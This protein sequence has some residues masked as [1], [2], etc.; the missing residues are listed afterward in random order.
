MIPL[1]LQLHN[2]MSYGSNSQPL[3]FKGI[4]LACLSGVNGVGKSSLLEAIT[5]AL[6]GKARA[7]SD[8]D[9]IKLG[10]QDMWVDFVFDLEG[11]KY[12]VVRKRSKQG[13]GQSSLEFMIA[14]GLEKKGRQE[15]LS[16]WTP[17]TGTTKAET[18]EAIVKTLR[19]EYDTF[20]NSAF[21]RQGHADE[22]TVKRP[23]ERKAILGDILGLSY[24]DHLESQAKEL[25]RHKEIEKESL[26]K[27]LEDM[28]L[29]LGDKKTVQ[30]EVEKIV[31]SLEGTSEEIQ[32]KEKEVIDLQKK[33]S[34]FETDL[35]KIEELKL[36]I[37]DFTKDI[38]DLNLDIQKHNQI[39]SVVQKLISQKE[40]IETKFEDYKKNLKLN[41]DYNQKLSKQ[42]E[43]NKQRSEIERNIDQK[44]H[45]LE[46]EKGQTK[47]KLEEIKN[48]L[49]KKEEIEEEKN[50]IEKELSLLKQKE[51]ELIEFQKDYH[52][53][54][55]RLAEIKVEL[56]QLKT[57]GEEIKN[58]ITILSKAKADCP[59]CKQSLTEEHRKEVIGELENQ[60]IQ[61]REEYKELR[62]KKI[63]FKEKTESLEENIKEIEIEL[64]GKSE[65]E[66]KLTELS[67][68]LREMENLTQE[69]KEQIEKYKKLSERLEGKDYDPE[70][71]KKLQGL[72]KEI[73]SISYD[74]KEHN[75]VKEKVKQLEKYGQLKSKL[76]Q[77]KEK[78]TDSKEAR[79][80]IEEI[81]KRKKVSIE[82][83]T[84]EK[85]DLA[86]SIK[87]LEIINNK[88]EEKNKTLIDLR[89]KVSGVQEEYGAVKE[90]YDRL[91]KIKEEEKEKQKKLKGAEEEKSVYDELALA[92]SKKG[93]QAMIIESAIPEIEEEANKLLSRMTDGKM[94][95]KFETQREKKTDGELQE[96]LD[97][98]ISDEQGMRAY[99]L[100][101]G[102]EAYRI[103]FAIRVALSK[104]LAHR[105]GAKLQFLVID[106]GFGTQDIQ[107]REH[108]VEAINSI[109]S[110]FKKILVITHIP[111]LREVFPT[112]IEVTKDEEGS[113][114]NVVG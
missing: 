38:Q 56:K 10:N 74:K 60:L 3:D 18:Q 17:M 67:K 80:R 94:Q 102:G 44:K 77:A 47:A 59:L 57:N 53:I 81:I 63:T 97:I 72:E 87:K 92:F 11:T 15:N 70:D 20:I 52:K 33:K 99:E 64:T 36:R 54:K 9:L 82:K 113:H 86:Q 66:K 85:E 43:L 83:D 73:F 95:V 24:Y 48:K 41:E 32:A 12:R 42:L 105:A 45:K 79:A 29:Q 22:F 84:K 68:D 8:D 76:D 46:M 78:I 91:I 51:K 6:W 75:Q 5:W 111:E 100:F 23:A 26:E 65:V 112:R 2:F 98:K 104:L 109:S 114:L 19:M 39:I 31:K 89:V 14:S 28:I 58:K 106:E 37:S 21:L 30:K 93:V 90:K 108:L 96:T 101:S 62:S 71:F 107:G 88:L 13:K 40:D 50:K 110:E 25:S 69:E 35:K 49:A 55:E 27:Q 7:K 16:D 34:D 1:C 103:N 4:D 61:K